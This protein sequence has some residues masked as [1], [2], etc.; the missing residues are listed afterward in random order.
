MV[1]HE[2]CCN[3]AHIRKKNGTDAAT[4]YEEIQEGLDRFDKLEQ[5]EQ[6]N[7]KRLVITRREQ[8][9]LRQ[10][11]IAENLMNGCAICGAEFP[12]SLL[13][14]AHMKPR[15]ECSESEKRDVNNVIPMC[16]LG[17]DALFELGLLFVEPGKVRVRRRYQTYKK[18]NGFLSQ[19]E[20]R[21]TTAWS[22]GRIGYF[23][24]HARRGARRSYT[25]V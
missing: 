5:W 8:A 11:L 18:L 2:T 3:P 20:G 15:A 14:T 6:L 21:P 23:K 10:Y 24:W 17:C 19:L 16:S 25:G 9:L 7:Q 13:V 12:Q 4:E 22:A 1:R